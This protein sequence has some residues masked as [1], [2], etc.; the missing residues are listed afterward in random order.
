MI[1]GGAFI[2]LTAFKA[3]LTASNSILVL[4]VKT[5]CAPAPCWI[6][7]PLL[8]M[9]K[10]HPALLVAGS[11]EP[12]VTTRIESVPLLM[13]ER[14]WEKAELAAAGC[15]TLQSR[16]KLLMTKVSCSVFSNKTTGCHE[17]VPCVSVSLSACV[18]S[19]MDLLYKL[20]SFN[21]IVYFVEYNKKNYLKS[22]FLS[23][24]KRS[25]DQ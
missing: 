10:S 1:V 23:H 3:F 22:A 6:S 15:Q 25:R 21:V 7:S 12:S 24:Y 2:S 4:L 16:L 5:W 20:M 9:A 18:C 14:S 13:S 11:K 8:K 17:I 19:N